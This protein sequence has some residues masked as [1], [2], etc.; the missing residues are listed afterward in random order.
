MWTA[1]VRLVLVLSSIATSGAWAEGASVLDIDKPEQPRVASVPDAPTS[2]ITATPSEAAIEIERPALL[3]AAE[4]KMEFMPQFSILNAN[5][6]QLQ[7]G[8]YIVDY[9]SVLEGVP[10]VHVAMAVP[11]AQAGDFRFLVNTQVGF[12]TIRDV[13]PVKWTNPAAGA[14]NTDRVRLTWL[15]ISLSS[16]VRYAVPGI[17]FFQPSV[18]VGAGGHWLLQRNGGA[19]PN[20][21]FWLPHVFVRP[22]LT[23]F[24]SA[25]TAHWFGGFLFG[26]TWYHSLGDVNRLRG[27][28]FDLSLKFLM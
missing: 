25:T 5:T 24:D 9:G 19:L 14:R 13:F 3:T 7:T 27:T 8:D 11:F 16:E 4:S 23:F 15:P 28:S 12:G 2:H 6:L 26:V 17:P 10:I 22:A 1:A 21:N 20:Q 18:T